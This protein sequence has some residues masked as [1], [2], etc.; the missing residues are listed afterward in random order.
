MKTV[1]VS[2]FSLAAC[3]FGVAAQP[4]NYATDKIRGVNLGGWLVLEPWITPSMFTQFDGK[5]ASEQGVD[6][7]TFC[8]KL[9][10]EE[11]RRQLTQHW[12]TWV[13]EDDIRT[14]ASYGI[15]HIRIPIGHWALDIAN[16]EPFVKGSFPYAVKAVHW[17]KKYGMKVIIDIHGQPG[18]QNGFDNSGIRGP[19]NWQKRPEFMER[20]LKVVQ[21]VAQ[22]FADP[23]YQEVVTMIQ[24][25]NE[26]AN[27][28]L[29][30]NDV[31]KFYTDA[32]KSITAASPHFIA[33]FHDAFLPLTTWNDWKATCPKS[34]MDTHIYHVFDTGLLAKNATEHL[35]LTCQQKAQVADLSARIPTMVGEWSLGTTDCAKWL[36]GYGR[37]ARYDGTYLTTAPTC[38]TCSCVGERDVRYYTPEYRHFLRQFTETQMDAYEAGAGW[39]FWNFKTEMAPEWD[40]MLGVKEGW[41]P[42]N[43]GRR[44]HGCRAN[45]VSQSPASVPATSL[46]SPKLVA[47]GQ[48]EGGSWVSS[49]R[50]SSQ[51]AAGLMATAGQGE[52]NTWVSSF[53]GKNQPATALV[54]AAADSTPLHATK[55]C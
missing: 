11:A 36:N 34:Y 54:L 35:Q 39:I 5:P 44:T 48:G 6:E 14:L 3:V 16:D 9:G 4:F 19:I 40:Y 8:Q 21:Q 30:M 20:S 45:V 29:D 32:Y 31:R 37:G 12:D 42:K 27:W 38:P 26:P 33:D 23:Q 2:L 13:T 47:A 51:P 7:Y 53:R 1:T 18:S 46:P 55:D 41:I 15:N 25:V 43:P 22:Y 49:F 50:E 24:P 17:A 52:G 28:G 10:P